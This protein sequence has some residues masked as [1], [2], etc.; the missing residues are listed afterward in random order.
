MHV[1]SCSIFLTVLQGGT[2]T[3]FHHFCHRTFDI[4]K[5]HVT[6]VL[7]ICSENIVPS[8]D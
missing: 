8:P 2:E 5:L 7:K 3:Q 1:K 4:F 6:F